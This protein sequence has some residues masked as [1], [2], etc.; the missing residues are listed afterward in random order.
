MAPSYIL[1][2]EDNPDDL[3][4]ASRIIGKACED[5]LL[6]ARDGEE[7]DEL[8][9]RMEREDTYRQ[10]KLVL[11]DLKLPKISGLD[12]LR[13]I[14]ESARLHELAVA[15]LTSSDNETDQ[16]KCWELGVVDYIYKPMTVDRLKSILAR[17]EGA[18]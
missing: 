1:L 13:G 3:F 11:L 14:R 8:L 2:I 16:Q 12:L 17:R 18:P 6:T 7:A 5:Q 10:I 4:L 9:K 15:I